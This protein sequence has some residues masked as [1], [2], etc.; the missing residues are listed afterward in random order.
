MEHDAQSSRRYKENWDE[1][2]SLLNA[3]DSEIARLRGALLDC[4]RRAEA[5]K[6]ECGMDPESPQALRNAQYQN[7]STM[8]HIALGTIKGPR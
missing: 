2:V 8:A 5:L 3:K 4:A 1:A 6:R 7:I